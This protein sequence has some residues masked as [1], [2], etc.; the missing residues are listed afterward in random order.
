[1]TSQLS[2]SYKTSQ[3]VHGA[4]AITTAN[5]KSLVKFFEGLW[6]TSRNLYDFLHHAQPSQIKLGWCP[7]K[8]WKGSSLQG[9]SFPLR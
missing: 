5:F 7:E 1:M 2:H 4:D 6:S 8:V 3:A 9:D